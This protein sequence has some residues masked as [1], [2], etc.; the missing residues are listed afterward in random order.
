MRAHIG[1]PMSTICLTNQETVGL[2]VQ[3]RGEIDKR[4][5]GMTDHNLETC[6]D[7]YKQIK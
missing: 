6:T 4:I 5:V 1:R 3:N 2:K 7:P